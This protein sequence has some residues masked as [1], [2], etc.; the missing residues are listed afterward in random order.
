[1]RPSP[2]LPTYG[3]A[4]QIPQVQ[5]WDGDESTL[6]MLLTVGSCPEELLRIRPSTPPGDDPEHEGY[7]EATG[8]PPMHFETFRGAMIDLERSVAPG[9]YARYFVLPCFL[10]LLVFALKRA[11][12]SANAYIYLYT[13]KYVY[14][15]RELQSDAGLFYCFVVSPL[16]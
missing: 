2:P 15:Y 13:S 5:Q 1:M 11:S 16:T 3:R 4:V 9:Q 10:V 6:Q 14:I 7:G 12:I 8:V